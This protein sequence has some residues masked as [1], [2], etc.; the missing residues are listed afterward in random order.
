MQRPLTPQRLALVLFTEGSFA[1]GPPVLIAMAPPG[2]ESATFVET[3]LREDGL[4][5]RRG[6]YTVDATLTEPGTW[7]AVLDVEGD[8]IPFSFAVKE[9]PEAPNI[10][11]QASRAASPTDVDALGVDP[12]CTQDP[13]CP[14]HARSLDELVGSGRPTAVLFATP[15]RC[16]TQYC[17]PVLDVLLPLVAEYEDRVDIV[18]VEIYKDMRSEDSVPTVEAWNLPSEPWFFGIDASGTI[19]ARLDGAFDRTELV[20]VLDQL[21]ASI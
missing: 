8:Q 20:A 6:L 4:P 15:A 2:V 14:L 1:S 10:G 12:L 19:V 17:G 13:P 7:N 9:A 11:Q 3:V 5:E 21:S 16:E 18:H